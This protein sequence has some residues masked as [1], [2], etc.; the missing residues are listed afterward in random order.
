MN[1]ITP[2][3]LRQW[4]DEDKKLLL[5]DVREPWEHQAYNIGGTLVPIGQIMRATTLLS[6]D[7]PIVV[8][9]EKGI[10]SVIAIQRLEEAGFKNLHNLAGGMKAWRGMA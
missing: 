9:C 2:A 6:K 1:Q 4:L 10:R 8:Y 5:I 3:V 7:V